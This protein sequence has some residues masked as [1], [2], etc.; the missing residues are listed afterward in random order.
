MENVPDYA[1]PQRK[2]RVRSRTKK[3]VS[4][5][6]AEGAPAPVVVQRVR[7]SVA[8]RKV[9]STGPGFGGKTRRTR[10]NFGSIP[11]GPRGY[12][13]YKPDFDYR[14]TKY[15]TLGDK[16]SVQKELGTKRRVNAGTKYALSLMDP[17]KFSFDTKVPDSFTG[18]TA[19]FKVKVNINVPLYA[20]SYGPDFPVGGFLSWMCPS[21]ET[22]IRYMHEFN[23]P[24]N[25]CWSLT[26]QKENGNCGFF[27][28]Q[29]DAGTAAEFDKSL[30]LQLASGTQTPIPVNLCGNVVM[31]ASDPSNVSPPFINNFGPDGSVFYGYSIN[32]TTAVVTVAGQCD[33]FGA[34]VANFLSLVV[35]NSTGVVLTAPLAINPQ[36]NISG[37]LL[38]VA[39]N[40]P[41]LGNDM[42]G[43]RLT[44]NAGMAYLNNTM[45]FSSLAIKFQ[46]G[47]VSDPQFGWMPVQMPS[48]TIAA[49]TFN[50]YRFVAGSHLL[51]FFGSDL[52]NG[53]QIAAR[54]CYGGV[55]ATR[56]YDSES[57]TYMWQM[58]GIGS[59]PRGYGPNAVKNGAYTFWLPMAERDL[60]LKDIPGDTGFS[61]AQM[62]TSGVTSNVI[63]GGPMNTIRARY[64]MC[65]ECTTTHQ[66]IPVSDSPE[67]PSVIKH[68]KTIVK[69]SSIETSM[70][71]LT[72][73]QIVEWSTLPLDIL[74]ENVPKLLNLVPNLAKA[75]GMFF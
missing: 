30:T 41:H 74:N 62:I 3:V 75:I 26:I 47:G 11:M 54:L 43:F 6:I 13:Q 45:N 22:P 8:E 36:G 16:G 21:F 73:Q 1:L 19:A 44:M 52:Q 14:G 33:V 2:K 59:A 66:I 61:S 4:K 51:S 46:W 68:L 38:S 53:G 20:A 57:N 56:E 58:I 40:A 60:E 9:A 5:A 28:L 31:G 10:G 18:K 37:N 69:D 72:H 48:Y 34:T 63:P 17:E 65:Y 55:P 27:D 50:R 29:G 15:S 7:Q 35:V 49:Q 24:A 67:N 12:T 39:F 32:L 71:N 64:V 23:V 42:V 70:E 25:D